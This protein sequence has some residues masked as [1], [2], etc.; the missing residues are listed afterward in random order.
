MPPA[1]GMETLSSL[2][3]ILLNERLK[4][5]SV[6][7]GSF[8]GLFAYTVITNILLRKS[9]NE[10]T[11]LSLYLTMANVALKIFPEGL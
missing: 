3:Q 10:L 4:Q 9:L 11:G 1:E 5:R 7:A 2:I 8:Q 6:W